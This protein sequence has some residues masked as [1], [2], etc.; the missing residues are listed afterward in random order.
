MHDTTFYGKRSCAALKQKGSGEWVAATFQWPRSSYKLT[1]LFDIFS[2]YHQHSLPTTA[3][4]GVGWVGGGK[5]R[6]GDRQGRHPIHKN[7]HPPQKLEISIALLHLSI[8][9][10]YKIFCPPPIYFTPL[11]YLVWL[12]ILCFERVAQNLAIWLRRRH[13]HLRP[14]LRSLKKFPSQGVTY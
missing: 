1:H 8:C 4:Q 9:S 10:P 6:V 14:L 3:Q 12:R 11:Q 7:F 13:G 2:D 5:G